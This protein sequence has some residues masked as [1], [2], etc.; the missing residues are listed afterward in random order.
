M[1]AWL[2]AHLAAAW[3]GVLTAIS[4]CP[5]ATNVAA[6]GFIA[7][8]VEQPRR[9]LL[10]GLLYALGRS[11]AYIGVAVLA[12]WG[13]AA[14]PQ[15]SFFLQ[16]K[17]NMVL[18][19]V[20]ILIGMLL[21][22]L[23]TLPGKLRL[24]SESLGNRVGQGWWWPLLIGMLFA[25]SFCPI[26]AAIFFGSLLPI[27]ATDGA[28][29]SAPAVYGIATAIPVVILAVVIVFAAHRLSRTYAT[30]ERIGRWAQII[31][32]WLFIIVG[33]SLSLTHVWARG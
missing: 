33:I 22:G 7:R 19:P 28:S 9:A 25:L 18:G 11:L 27:A 5:M 30:I 3:L 6:M 14:I 21:A 2:I 20:L 32:G 26:S 1:S 13:L 10:G 31:T 4:P 16:G 8:K 12:L 23:I 24:G 29:I 17:M 15:M